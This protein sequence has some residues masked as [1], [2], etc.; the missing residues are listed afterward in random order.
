MTFAEEF[1]G[2]ADKC[3]A[4]KTLILHIM[5]VFKD[6]GIAGWDRRR[7]GVFFYNWK[8]QHLNDPMLADGVSDAQTAVE[9]VHKDKDSADAEGEGTSDL[10]RVAESGDGSESAVWLDAAWEEW[11]D[12]EYGF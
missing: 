8:R 2:L 12:E 4:R 9:D 1:F 6:R 5:A 10:A 11:G 7:I 3:A